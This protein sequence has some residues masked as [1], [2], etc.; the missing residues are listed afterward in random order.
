MK[1]FLNCYRVC[2]I[3][4]YTSFSSRV[5][6]LWI[7]AF[8]WNIHVGHFG[9]HFF[10]FNDKGVRYSWKENIFGRV[11]KSFSIW[12]LKFGT[13]GHI[14]DKMRFSKK[15]TSAILVAILLFLALYV[16]AIAQKIVFLSAAECLT[17]QYTSFLSRDSFLMKIRII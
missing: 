10:I 13:L 14:L 1:A 4:K 17:F 2:L 6:F 9:Y 11:Q 16:F 15:F 12:I 3:F 8:T 5:S 7:S